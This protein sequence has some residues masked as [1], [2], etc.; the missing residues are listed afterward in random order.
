[1]WDATQT[2]KYRKA[3]ASMEMLLVT[4]ENF[5]AS[6]TKIK[7]QVWEVRAAIVDISGGLILAEAPRHHICTSRP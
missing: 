2:Q 1:M 5:I 6:P 7:G 4:L 3:R